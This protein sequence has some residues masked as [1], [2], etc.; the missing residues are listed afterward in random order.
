MSK[1]LTVNELFY[2]EEQY[3]LLEPS[4]NGFISLENIKTVRILHQNPAQRASDA[5]DWNS[6]VLSSSGVDQERDGR[7][8]GVARER[9]PRLGTHWITKFFMPF[10][11]KKRK[12]RIIF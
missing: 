1:T 3:A 8:E 6:R 10:W 5:C 9:S 12:K 7:D 4:R 11:E 2:M